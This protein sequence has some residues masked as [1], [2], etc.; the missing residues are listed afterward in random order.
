M[1]ATGDFIKVWRQFDGF[2][3]ETLTKAWYY[4]QN[5]DKKQRDVS[6]MKE[7]HAQYRITGNCFDLA[8]WLL[9]EFKAEGVEAYPI[10]HDLGTPGAYAAVIAINVKGNRKKRPRNV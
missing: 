8:L 3:M 7:H 1:H 9:H 5:P 4:H 2:P 6:L 10:G